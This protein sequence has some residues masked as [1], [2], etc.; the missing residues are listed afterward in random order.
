MFLK[1]NKFAVN[2]QHYVTEPAKSGN[3]DTLIYLL[4]KLSQLVTFNTVISWLH[5]V[6]HLNFYDRMEI[7]YANTEM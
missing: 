4:F 6:Q 5:N 2:L 1:D 7:L 3:V